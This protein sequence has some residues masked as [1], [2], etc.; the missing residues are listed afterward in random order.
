MCPEMSDGEGCRLYYRSS[1]LKDTSTRTK[2]LSQVS[3]WRCIAGHT[4]ELSPKLAILR[5][6]EPFAAQFDA[7]QPI[8]CS[9]CSAYHAVSR[10]GLRMV[11]GVPIDFGHFLQSRSSHDL[12]PSI[13]VISGCVQG[14]R[15]GRADE[16]DR[17]TQVETRSSIE[18]CQLLFQFYFFKR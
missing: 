8:F 11:H 5:E 1:L 15:I 10:P 18:R 3:S 16:R 4:K 9:I 14:V 17:P 6:C 13:V 12:S 2:Q 7:P